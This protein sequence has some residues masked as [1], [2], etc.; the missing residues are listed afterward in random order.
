M[1]NVGSSVITHN[2]PTTLVIYNRPSSIV[3][4]C[5]SGGEHSFMNNQPI[6]R[7][8]Y[9]GNLHF[10]LGCSLG[11]GVMDNLAYVAHLAARLNIEGRCC[12]HNFDFLPLAR[13]VDPL[14]IT[15]N[16]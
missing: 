7:F 13:A 2:I 16:S 6:D 14:S 9:L 15:Q 12:Q 5:G 10:P 4:L 8:S 1:Q 11:V 3:N